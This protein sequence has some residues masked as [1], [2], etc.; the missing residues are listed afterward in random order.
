MYAC[1]D[2]FFGDDLIA[3]FAAWIVDFGI[4]LLVWDKVAI[5]FLYDL[6]FGFY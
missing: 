1:H 4:E 3:A 2:F 5:S 6:I